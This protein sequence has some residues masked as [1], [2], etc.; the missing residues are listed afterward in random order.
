M[1]AD[2]VHLHGATRADLVLGHHTEFDD[3]LDHLLRHC[4]HRLAG[5]TEMLRL[6]PSRVTCPGG[7]FFLL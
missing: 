2:L 5:C 1:W 6:H 4:G 3:G 7:R